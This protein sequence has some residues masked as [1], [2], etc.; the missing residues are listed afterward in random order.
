LEADVAGIATDTEAPKAFVCGWPIEHSKSPIIHSYWLEN[1]AISGH[2]EK[3]AV[4][5]EELPRFLRGIRRNG[6]IGGN[7]TIPHKEAALQLVDRADRAAAS[8][9]AVNTLWYE[10]DVLIGGNTDWIGF[11]ANLDERAQGW[12]DPGKTALVIGAGGASR[13]IIYALLKKE[14]DNIIIANR[15]VQKAQRLAAEFGT[16]LNAIPLEDVP[17]ILSKV[18]LLVNTTSMGMVNAPPIPQ[19]ILDSLTALKQDALVSDIVYTPLQ[20]PILAE[21]EKAGRQTVDGLGM[22]LHQAVPGFEK[23]FGFKPQVTEELRKTVLAAMGHD[24]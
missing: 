12:S 22:L 1:Y 23:W 2:Y 24:T 20:T 13:A 4:S 9:G 15:T 6:F 17:E 7:I 8:I 16:S 21:A 5:T 3:I 10:G 11:A 18:D 14:F 19:P